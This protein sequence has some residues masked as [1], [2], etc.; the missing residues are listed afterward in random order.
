MRT[1][2]LLV[3]LT[4][5]PADRALAGAWTLH[6]GAAQVLAG[7]TVSRA[8]QRFD[9]AG[10]PD[11]KIVFNKLLIQD[12]ME[13]G[14]TDAL[15]LFAVPEL[16]IAQSDETGAGVEQF[17]TSSVEAGA[18]VLLS[19]RIGMLSLQASIKSAGAFDMSTSA[20][21]E[22]GRQIELRLLYGRNFR[23]LR[24]DGYIDV[25]VAERW[26]KRP[27][28]NEMAFDVSAGLWI[29]PKYLLLFRSFNT[30]AGGGA[31]MPYEYYR[32]HKVEIGLVRRLTQRWSLQTGTFFSPAGQNIV[33][34]QGAVMQLWYR[35]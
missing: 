2:F 11:G 33:Q 5:T 32:Q 14:V 1:T 27:R 16:V 31:K 8:T 9:R 12:W 22:A 30:I 7:V 26:I 20:G 25:E 35:Y 19:K 6:R 10:V 17:R 4:L 28:P 29:S 21:G 23:L 13:Y 24:R 34:E 15:T 18:R 3:G